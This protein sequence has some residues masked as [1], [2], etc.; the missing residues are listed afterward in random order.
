LPQFLPLRF[1][2][3]TLSFASVSASC[4]IMALTNPHISYP[5][6]SLSKVKGA[7]LRRAD[8]AMYEQKR[9]RKKSQAS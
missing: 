3:G 4:R 6:P 9:L 1:F 8:K 2:Q 5:G 7:L